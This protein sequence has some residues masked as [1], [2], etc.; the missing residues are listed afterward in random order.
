VLECIAALRAATADPF[1]SALIVHVG[2]IVRYVRFVPICAT[3]QPPQPNGGLVDVEELRA[4]ILAFR[5]AGK[6]TVCFSEALG[7]TFAYWIATSCEREYCATLRCTHSLTHSCL[8]PDIVIEP[9]CEL[10]V[11]GVPREIVQPFLGD[12]WEKF[13]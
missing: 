11:K 12:V 3:H 13:G 8:P 9:G 6:L 10:E 2:D 1:V 7:S 4:A 5:A